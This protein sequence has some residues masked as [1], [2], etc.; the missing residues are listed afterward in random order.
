MKNNKHHNVFDESSYILGY[1]FAEA[2][3]KNCIYWLVHRVDDEWIGKMTT[4]EHV[5]DDAFSGKDKKSI[6]NFAKKGVTE[7][8]VIVLMDTMWELSKAIYTAFHDKFLV[9]GGSGEFLKIAKT[10][11]YLQMRIGDR[12]E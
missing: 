5:D 11:S 2:P 4:R 1:W 9:R 10:K 3:N 7:E 12:N 6:T 8:E